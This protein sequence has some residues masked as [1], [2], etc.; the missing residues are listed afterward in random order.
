[1]PKEGTNFLMLYKQIPDPNRMD[2]SPTVNKEA[3]KRSFKL[4][5]VDIKI[6]IPEW[7]NEENF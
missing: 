7:W 5:Q 6:E 1:M 2:V 3:Y 4:D